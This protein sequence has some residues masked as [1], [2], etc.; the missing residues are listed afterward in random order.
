MPYFVPS[1]GP[2]LHLAPPE[3]MEYT[4][5]SASAAGPRSVAACRATSKMLLRAAGDEHE[6]GGASSPLP[7]TAAGP[8]DDVAE[9]EGGRGVPAGGECIGAEH[10]RGAAARLRLGIAL[11]TAPAALRIAESEGRGRAQERKGGGTVC[12]IADANVTTCF[13]AQRASG[14]HQGDATD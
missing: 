4:R 7:S 9:Q 6:G 10:S 8:D 14:R 1:S 12:G 5:R 2:T 13:A 3:V 11:P